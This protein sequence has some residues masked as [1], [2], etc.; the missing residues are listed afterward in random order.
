M[1]RAAYFDLTARKVWRDDVWRDGGEDA[2]LH[3][4]RSMKS[5]KNQRREELKVMYARAGFVGGV[6]LA[7]HRYFLIIH[8]DSVGGNGGIRI[9]AP[10]QRESAEDRHIHRAIRS[11]Q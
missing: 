2:L 11:P 6:H 3:P 10:V 5:P 7:P 1:K 9:A 8:R 4:W